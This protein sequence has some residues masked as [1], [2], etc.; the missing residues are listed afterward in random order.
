M[1]AFGEV[2][3]LSAIPV[4]PVPERASL[5]SGRGLFD[6]LGCPACRYV[7]EATDAYLDWFAQAEWRDML[8]R[9]S[10]S[11]GM[12]VA[13]TG[14][15]LARSGAGARLRV[16]YQHVIE[17][18]LEDIAA[19]PASCPACE[20]ARTAADRLLGFLLD[21]A[22]PGDRRTYKEHGGLCLPHLRRAAVCRR[23]ADILWLVRFMIVRLTVA[24]PGLDV[25]IGS[26]EDTSAG[27]DQ[28]ECLVCVV[29]AEATRSQ[30]DREVRQCLCIRHVRVAAMTAEAGMAG[31]VA[32][33]AALHAARLE[34][35]L[36]GRSRRL[37]NYLSVRAREALAD[38]DCPVCRGRE[39]V[40]EQ[41][42]SRVAEALRDRDSA[43][44]AELAL[45]FRHARDLLRVDE[46]AG[47]VVEAYVRACGR[48][49]IGQ[50]K[51]PDDDAAA[52]RRVV[53]FLDASA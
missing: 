30:R 35:V 10:D 48:Q 28:L 27:E 16:V 33:Q 25:L 24:A 14:R 34:R 39:A 9:L 47:R 40:S 3:V 38:P 51:A 53:A 52:V 29:G 15:L 13:H 26:A 5:G 42:V 50:L 44:S 37:G 36:G 23:G 49:L 2:R 46:Q 31:V 22:T 11:R 32:G 21:E 8:S 17:A 7:A 18:A 41:E 19:S 1:G 45:C 6:Q 43:S 20:H 4:S 12:C